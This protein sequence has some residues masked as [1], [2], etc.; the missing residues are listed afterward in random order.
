MVWNLAGDSVSKTKPT[1]GGRPARASECAEG[2][3]FL[4]PRLLTLDSM[5]AK[6]HFLVHLLPPTPQTHLT[7]WNESWR[8]TEAAASAQIARV[9][10]VYPG[11]GSLTPGG[12]PLPF[13]RSGCSH[14]ARKCL[15]P[16]PGRE[17][18][19][20][21]GGAWRCPQPERST[22]VCRAGSCLGD[23]G[24]APAPGSQGPGAPGPGETPHH[25]D[26]RRTH[27]VSTPTKAQALG[28]SGLRRLLPHHRPRHEDAASERRG[29]VQ[30]Q[31]S[32]PT[33]RRRKGF[34][35]LEVARS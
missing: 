17:L 10:E 13:A 35:R 18:V 33:R 28:R 34:L 11:L 7:L 32:R 31:P 8:L 4:Q 16:V 5:G 20:E 3:C 2:R 26:P 9:L 23:P 24:G 19:T 25:C 1:L 21:H 30:G 15:W 14:A 6:L 12:P 22:G 27:R 29:A